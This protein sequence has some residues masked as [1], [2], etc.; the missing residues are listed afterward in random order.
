MSEDNFDRA[1]DKLDGFEGGYVN[2]P[3]DRGGETYK[4]IARRFH[5]DW[6]GWEIIDSL[7]NTP[8]FPHNLDNAI[9]LQQL[10]KDFYKSEYWDKLKGDLLPFEIAEELFEQAVNMGLSSAVKNLQIVLNILN[11]NEKFYSNIA[12]DGIFGN[13]TL[14]TLKVSL[15]RNGEKLIFNLLNILQ[16]ATY[17]ELMLSNEVNEKYVGWFKRID[18]RKV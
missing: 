5:P 2:D 8:G 12:A 17:I 3:D 1:H 15:A 7:R 9:A 11:R 6:E 10:V 13:Q 4:G 16:G 14:S 18:I